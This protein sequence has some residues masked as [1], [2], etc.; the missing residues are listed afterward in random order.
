MGCMHRSCCRPKRVMVICSCESGFFVIHGLLRAS[1]PVF[2]LLAS[3]LR[4]QLV[5][6]STRVSRLPQ[7]SHEVPVSFMLRSLEDCRSG[8]RALVRF[9]PY[10]QTYLIPGKTESRLATH[11]FHCS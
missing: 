1:M 2:E 7:G 5:K 10:F 8:G 11:L 6:K 3:Q 4:L 9:M